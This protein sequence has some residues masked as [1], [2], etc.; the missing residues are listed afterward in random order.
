MPLQTAV[1]PES[2]RLAMPERRMNDLF[3]I[4]LKLNKRC[5]LIVG[6]GKIAALRATQLIRTGA[7]VTIVAPKVSAEIEGLAKAG[8]VVLIRRGFERCDLI[9]RYFIVIGATNDPKVQ[10]AVS[11][12]AERCGIFCNIVDNA[13]LSNFYTPAVLERGD[14]KI[15]ISTSGRC[16]PLAGRLRQY[17]EEAIPENAADLTEIMGHLRS[18]LKLEIPGDLARQKKLADDFVAK[19]LKK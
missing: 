6:G 5:A 2:R 3:P 9:K 4:F 19:V 10:Q 14:L 12:E 18:K 1:V 8:S 15:A 17:L 16:P 11:E 7:S 13:G